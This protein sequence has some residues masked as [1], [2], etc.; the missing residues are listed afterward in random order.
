MRLQR[1]GLLAPRL[2]PP[3]APC[4]CKGA[5]FWPRVYKSHQP[6]LAHAVGT[7][8]HQARGG[9]PCGALKN[10]ESFQCLCPRRRPAAMFER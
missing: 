9:R 7:A 1:R 3:A 4:A 6:Y 10:V 5:A 2:L 8:E